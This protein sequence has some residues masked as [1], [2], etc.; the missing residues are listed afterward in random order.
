RS[1]R[2]TP[3]TPI[4]TASEA[5]DIVLQDT[6]QVSLVEQKSRDEDEARENVEEKGEE[7]AKFRNTPSP[8]TIRSPRIHSTLISSDTEKL[9]ELTVNDPTP[10]SSTPSSSSPSHNLSVANRLLSLF[11]SKPGCFRRYK[12]F[13]QELQGQYGYLFEHLLA[14]FM[15]RQKFDEVAQ[16]LQEIIMEALPKLVD[17]HIKKILQTRVPLH[18]A[19]GLILEREKSQADVEK[20]IV[21]A[22]QK[23]RE[24][25]CSEISSQLNDAI[26]NQIPS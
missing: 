1:T 12:S 23:E 10:S 14:K 15:P 5:E 2:L 26:A 6:L 13:F 18:V 19:Q 9:Q 7:I 21:D 16:R 25:L 8:T 11:K 22:I 3:P 24:N 20:M 4:P 17:E